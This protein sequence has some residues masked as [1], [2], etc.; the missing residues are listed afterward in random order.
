MDKPAFVGLD[1]E[2]TGLDP[3]LDT[4]LEVGMVIFDMDLAPLAATSWVVNP[5]TPLLDHLLTMMPKVVIEMHEKSG[6]LNDIPHGKTHHEV[7]H[8][9]VRFLEDHEATGLPMLGS[10]ITFDRSFLTNEMPY[11]LGQFHYQSVDA[12]SVKLATQARMQDS[13]PDEAFTALAA[14]YREAKLKALNTPDDLR[15]PHRPIYD[16]CQSAGLIDASADLLIQW[17]Q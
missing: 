16:L 5:G 11:L 8:S 12:T 14:M 17:G 6:L 1:I 9:A 15:H 10:S 13:A 4:I 3:D 7:V 2:T